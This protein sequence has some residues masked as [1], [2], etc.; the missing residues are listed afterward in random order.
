MRR[1]LFLLLF[2]PSL[3][4]AQAGTDTLLVWQTYASEQRA[5]VSQYASDDERRP[6]TF[7]VDDLPENRTGLVANDA[8]FVAETVGRAFRVDP[9]EAAFVFRIDGA[10]FGVDAEPGR[11]LLLRAT[12]GRT[13]T[14]ALASPYWR[15]ISRDELAEMTDRALY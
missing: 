12:F 10:S 6:I 9:V 5:R 1:L 13:K 4:A 11:T 7:V 3:A 2:V 14:G 15:V 8:Q